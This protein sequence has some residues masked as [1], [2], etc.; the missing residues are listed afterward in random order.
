VAIIFFGTKNDYEALA[1]KSTRPFT[2]RG[3]ADG[4]FAVFPAQLIYSLVETLKRI[5]RSRSSSGSCQPESC[6]A[7]AL[8]PNRRTARAVTHMLTQ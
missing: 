5:A 2:R 8:T 6:S 3:G 4:V 7:L 1:A